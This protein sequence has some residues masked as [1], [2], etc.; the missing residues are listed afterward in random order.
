MLHRDGRILTDE[1]QGW[2]V[3]KGKLCD[4]E[5]HE[6]TQGQLRAYAIVWQLAAEYGKSNSTA[7]DTLVR[8]ASIDSPTLKARRSRS[9]AQASQRSSEPARR[10]VAS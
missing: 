6:L 1:W 4:P 9:H 7:G 10:R 5:G 8:L 3:L 2:G